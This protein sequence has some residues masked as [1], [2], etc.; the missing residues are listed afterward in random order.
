MALVDHSLNSFVVTVP[1]QGEKF[2]KRWDD[3]LGRR[4]KTATR[5]L[6]SAVQTNLRIKKSRDAGEVGG[7]RADGGFP[8]V[9]TQTLVRNVVMDNPSKHVGRVGIR[10]GFPAGMIHELGG[11]ISPK[12]KRS[13][14]IPI[15]REAKRWML[16]GASAADFKPARGRELG[17]IMRP[18]R[19]TLLVEK[20]GGRNTRNIIHFI[21]VE[22]VRIPARPFLV[23]TAKQM[24]PRIVEILAAPLT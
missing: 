10:R 1:W 18:G 16:S 24:E 19:P 15:S 14:V 20:V 22:S 7:S 8:G 5:E 4:T 17:K 21:L 13:L 2:Y 12:S 3:E 11:V 6:H 23:P 9:N